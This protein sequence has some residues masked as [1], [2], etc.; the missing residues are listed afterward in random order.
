MRIHTD[1]QSRYIDEFVRP[2]VRGYV[3]TEVSKF[4]VNEVNSEKRKDLEAILKNILTVEFAEKGL[5]LDQFVL[6]DIAFS[7]QYADSIEKKQVALEGQ[8]QKEY[9]AEQIRRLAKGNADA[10]RIEAEGKAKAIEVEAEAQAHALNVIEQELRKNTNLLNYS[11]I[12]KIAPNIN[13]MLL[14]S[15]NPLLL[16]LPSI[17]SLGGITTTTDLTSTIE[18]SSQP[19]TGGANTGN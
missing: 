11:Y 10:I 13:V 4:K 16:P 14:P 19:D 9:E 18:A 1:W 5:I 7:E 17:D 3:R 15:D 2:I 6:R 12:D 8:T